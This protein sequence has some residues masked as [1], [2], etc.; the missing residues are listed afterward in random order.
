QLG[1]LGL[2][3]D[4][5]SVVANY[6][7]DIADQSAADRGA[8]AL[9]AGR[10]SV[11]KGIATAIEAAAISGVTLKVAGDGPLAGE[12]RDRA[13]DAPVEFLGRVPNERVWQLLRG[14]AMA[15]VPS[16]SADVMPYAALEA[17]AA[18]VPIV[19]SD[20]GS[21]PEVVGPEHC[22]PRRDSQAFAREMRRLFDDP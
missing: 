13:V 5:V 8:Y 16:V 22:V 11:G 6:V 9:V 14:A 12:L 4:R 15:V 2:P 3:S 10:L 19:A 20:S 18:G 17:M 7:P 1:L 21:L